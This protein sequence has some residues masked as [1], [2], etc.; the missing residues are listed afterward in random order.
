VQLNQVPAGS[1][2]GLWGDVA[3]VVAQEAAG[4]VHD[5]IVQQSGRTEATRAAGVPH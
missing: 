3:L 4:G 2:N 5:V 1:L